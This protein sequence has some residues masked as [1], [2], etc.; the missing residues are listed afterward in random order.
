M[1]RPFAGL[2]AKPLSEVTAEEWSEIWPSPIIPEDE[3]LTIEFSANQLAGGRLEDAA[4][5]SIADY[6]QR[7]HPRR[8]R[9]NLSGLTDAQKAGLALIS[10]SLSSDEV[11]KPPNT[12]VLHKAVWRELE[13]NWA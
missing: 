8:L 4:G 10:E 6:L 13:L 11:V 1:V 3:S 9:A 7:P 5:R 2:V 12:P